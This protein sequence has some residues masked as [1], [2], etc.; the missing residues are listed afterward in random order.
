M[1]KSFLCFVLII[2][3]SFW[4]CGSSVEQVKIEKI[5]WKESFS[6]E[7]VME[8]G[9]RKQVAFYF[10]PYS[11]SGG[12]L[13]LINDNEDVAYCLIQDVRPVS[14]KQLV[15]V[16]CK[17][18]SV[19]EANFYIIDKDSQ[20]KSDVIKIIV[21]EVQE[22][23]DNSRIVYLNYSGDKYHYSK[24]CAGTSAYE[25]TLNKALR[26]LKEPCSKCTD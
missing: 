19:G 22:E 1:R 20:V 10:E 7:F 23:V 26:L 16:G 8:T 25:S 2:I 13:E 4:G 3:C 12:N 5:V 6:T 18:L 11:A 15:I 24:S 9:D 21:K 14:G 17:G